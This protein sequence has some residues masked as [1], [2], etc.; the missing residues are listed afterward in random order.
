MSLDRTAFRARHA[1]TIARLY[2]ASEAA[3]WR[4]AADVFEAALH[5]SV[6]HRFPE[7][8]SAQ[9]VERYLESLHV[10][11]LALACACRAGDDPAWEHFIREYRPGLYAAAR[12][13]AGDDGR[14]LADGLYAELFGLSE[15]DGERRSLLTYYHGRSRL[16]TWLRSVMVQRHIDRRRAAARLEPLDE[17]GIDGLPASSVSAALDP[18]RV[19]YVSMAQGVLDDAIGGL[20]PK[21]KLR[22]RLYYGQQL[23]LSQI[24]RVTGEHEATVSRKLDRVR[25]DLRAAVETLLR[26]EHGLSEAAVRECLEAAAD[27]PELHLTRL[28]ARNE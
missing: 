21:D 19:A 4:V 8:A 2:A 25:R 22:L 15:R 26:R 11:E 12:A 3:R 10:G 20:E 16:T 27:A 28:L 14:D 18:A 24:G 1:R 23:T 5:G 13:V 9:D 7:A 17:A 6:S